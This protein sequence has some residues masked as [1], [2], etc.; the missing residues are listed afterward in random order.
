MIATAR[1]TTSFP[2]ARIDSRSGGLPV[3]V[4][5]IAQL[6]HGAGD[7]LCREAN[8]RQRG[9][10]SFADALDEP[11]ATL[12]ATNI[13]SGETT[14]LHSFGVGPQGHSFHRHAGHRVFTAVSG[15]G[16]AQLRFSTA[17]DAHLRAT[18]RAFVETL[19]YVDI[20]P[21]SLFTV[22]FGGG[23]WH[24]FAPLR[25]DSSHPTLFA[26]SC[27]TNELGGIEDAALLEEVGEG[28]A[29]IHDLTELLP[30]PV[31][32]FLRANPLRHACVP[33]LALSLNER[34]GSL[35][36]AACGLFRRAAGRMRSFAVAC[37]CRVSGFVGRRG[38]AVV[39][40]PHAVDGSLLE[41]Q[42]VERFEH[43]DSFL[44]VLHGG[45]RNGN[46]AAALLA[47]VLEGFLSNR[48][49]G[50]SWLMKLRNVL[51]WPLR[52]RTSPLGCPASSL[53]SANRE[54][55]FAGQY[56][57]LDQSID[58][59]GLRAEVMLGAD[60]R[61]LRFRSCVGVRFIGD[62]AHIT[63][64]TR[65]QF[66]NWFGRLYLASIDKVHRSYISPTMLSMAVEHAQRRMQAVEDSTVLAF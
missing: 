24:Q 40:L 37:R 58:A 63:L 11:A 35:L 18:P 46:P 16:G 38:H 5:L 28:K 27:H 7:R 19:N 36:S 9:H 15:S 17:S 25:A 22:R 47:D 54:K 23:T 45:A 2:T 66:R 41:R 49:I 56:P 8:A 6:G 20:P 21:D 48:P 3:E 13:G 52:L 14:A 55:L 65:V 32:D 30:Q 59:R 10:G 4:T 42:L 12:A 34:P 60:D 39:E 29:T 1:P 62:D 61:H 33:T 53:L 64:A 50:V 26:L 57:I 31:N 51:V 44:L 43:E